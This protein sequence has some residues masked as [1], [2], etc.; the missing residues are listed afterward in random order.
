MHLCSRARCCGATVGPL[1][2]DLVGGETP[3]FVPDI[4]ITTLHHLRNDGVSV[5][6]G[7]MGVVPCGYGRVF[8]V[9]IACDCIFVSVFEKL[10]VIVARM[11]ITDREDH[12]C[13]TMLDVLR[14]SQFYFYACNHNGNH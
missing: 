2:L 1:L 10:D 13:L 12:V 6:M 9:G 5:E 11:A 8:T 4:P 3:I 7:E 14:F